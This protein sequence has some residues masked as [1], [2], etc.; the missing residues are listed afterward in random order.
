M[1][2]LIDIAVVDDHPI[3]RDSAAGWVLADSSDIRV[4][5]T[6]ATVGDLLAGPGARPASS[7]STWTSATGP[8]LTAT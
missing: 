1:S 3:I 2:P 5:A 7:C 8:P 4:I 6:A